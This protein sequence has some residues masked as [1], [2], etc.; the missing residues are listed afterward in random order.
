VL[1]EALWDILGIR[2]AIKNHLKKEASFLI[3]IGLLLTFFLIFFLLVIGLH[4]DQ[5]DIVPDNI[6]LCMYPLGVR[7]ERRRRDQEKFRC[8]RNSKENKVSAFIK[9]S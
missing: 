2:F 3:H 9:R 5:H 7:G 4:I 6:L 8:C 1:A